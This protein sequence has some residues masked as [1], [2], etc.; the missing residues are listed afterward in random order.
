M[1][2]KQTAL[3][4][5]LKLNEPLSRHTSWR[6]GGPAARYFQP[7]DIDDLAMYL[8]S[9][10]DDEEIYWVGLGSNL[11]VRDGGFDGSIICTSGVMNGL[12]FLDNNQVEVEAGVACPKVAK[13]CAKQGLKNAAFL[14][15]IP[16]TMGGALAMNAGAFG[17]ETWEIVHSVKT[18]DRHGQIRQRMPDEYEIDYRHVMGPEGEWFVS[19]VLQLQVGDTEELLAANKDLLA[20]RGSTQPTQQPNAGSVFRNPEGDY[21]ARLIEEAGLKG[22]CIGGAC[23]SDKHAN[24]IVNTGTA[25]AADIENLIIKV[26]EVVKQIHGIELQREVCIVGERLKGN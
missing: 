15:G 16:G 14:S 8:S 13:Q 19:T 21:A 7:A 17:G 12:Q 4:G 1:S 23:V 11:L 26:A 18:I 6:V 3:Q 25:T 9:L 22:T 10:S 2:A 5:E 24:F 20:K